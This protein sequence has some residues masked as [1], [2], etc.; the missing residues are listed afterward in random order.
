MKPSFR[1]AFMTNYIT[2]SVSLAS[3]VCA[4]SGLLIGSSAALAQCGASG[5]S[6]PSPRVGLPA[7]TRPTAAQTVTLQARVAALEARM[8]RMISANS[9]SVPPAFRGNAAAKSASK[10]YLAAMNARTWINGE[11]LWQM[12]PSG[13]TCQLSS[14]EA[15]LNSSPCS[16]SF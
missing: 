1:G 2:T 10:E 3:L 6:S 7:I 14:S 16:S 12:S 5:C 9:P 11:G 13:V 4:G 8:T 15:T